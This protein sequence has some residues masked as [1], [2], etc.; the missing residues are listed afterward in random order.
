MSTLVY[1]LED[2]LDISRLIERS[3][4]QQGF[5]MRSF[6]RLAE[7]ERELRRQTPDLCLIDLSLP[8][9]DGLSLINGNT[10][11]E[12]MPRVIVTGRGSVTDKVVGLEIGADDYIVKPFEPRELVAR[13]RAVLRRSRKSREAAESD[14][15]SVASFGGWTANLKACTLTHTDG[16]QVTLSSS[17]NSLLEAFLRAPGRVLSRSNL[18]DATQGRSN[19]PFDRSMD[20]RV[21][22]LRRKIARAPDD[23]E[24]IRTVYGAGYIFSAEVDWSD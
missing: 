14:P 16:H 24:V 11:P 7:F 9:G 23:G 13:L 4:V 3:L 18:L 1:L 21:C 17:E 2:D 20:A 15:H 22:R 12:N 10:L 6:R 19:E 5:T 8:D